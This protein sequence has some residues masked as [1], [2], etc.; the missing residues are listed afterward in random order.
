MNTAPIQ[1]LLVEDNPV[2]ARVAQSILRSL[3]EELPVLTHWVD[4]AEK[5]VAELQASKYELLLLDYQ[6]PHATG[7]DVL[8]AIRRLPE[9]C[10]PAVIM[11]TASGS[12]KIA[13]EAMKNG[14]R[15][16][17]RKEE[18]DVAPLTRAIM[19][20]LS[21]KR[22]QEQVNAYL[23]QT[24]AELKMAHHLQHALLPQQFPLF[25]PTASPD[26]TRLRFEARYI[27]TTELGGDFYDVFPLSETTAGIFVCDVMGHGVRAA[28][29]TA[30]IRGLLEELHG[31]AHDPSQLLAGINHG[32]ST[33]LRATEEPLFATAV[34][35][36]ADIAAQELRY[37][38]AGHPAPLHLQKQSARVEPLTPPPLGGS[39]A[40]GMIEQTTYPTTVTRLAAGDRL[41]L[42]TDGIYEVFDAQQEEFGKERLLAAAR[43][44]GAAPVEQWLDNVIGASQAFSASGNFS[45]DVCLLA[46]EFR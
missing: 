24:Q 25:P 44:A 12:E 26:T 35:L 46:V 17:L 22:L 29:V 8:A 30:L 42:F 7:L 6:L 9:S 4:T 15:D 34:Y 3:P 45:D 37:A 39:L 14:A 33:I 1:L 5:A 2:D 27:S 41:L 10:Q 36:V 23:V 43:Q 20:A 19:S 28:L 32:L 31:M 21:Q 16:Y 40:L 13:V 38:N 18:L 11:L